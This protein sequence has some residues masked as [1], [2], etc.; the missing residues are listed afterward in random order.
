[1]T[2]PIDVAV[3]RQVY[4]EG[5]K[6]GLAKEY[7]EMIRKNNADVRRVLRGMEQDTLRDMTQ[8][9]FKALT[10]DLRASQ[11]DNIVDQ[12]HQLNTNLEGL[13]SAE[14]IFEVALL[15]Q[16]YDKVKEAH[17][18]WQAALKNPIQSSGELLEPFIKDL[19]AR[20]IARLENQL[21]LSRAR[22]MTIDQ[23]VRAFN[24][25]K[26]KGYSDGI[27]ARNWND[28]R[29]V[30]RTATQHVSSAARSA[31]WEAN[32]DIMDKYQWVSTLDG[33][34]SNVCK[35]LDGR[36]F[37]VGEGPTPPI[38]PNC[39]STTVP[40]FPPSRFDD[41]A[42]RS[43]EF[44]PVDVN[45]TYYEWLKDQPH[46]FQDDALGKTR[47]KLF[48]DGGLTEKEFSDLQ[49]GKDFLPLTLEEMKKKMPRAFE[50][51]NIN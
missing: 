22:G 3:R 1:M 48:R 5:L 24:G 29:T 33:V 37:V 44:G 25:T 19:S 38:H 6:E 27:M 16:A 8:R 28:A 36:V 34:T 47:A 17:N 50:K 7:G 39:R 35:S 2:D 26:A 45:T 12:V 41:G 32:S 13:A 23:T 4:L 21:R 31:V 49:I 51:A 15:A 42:T 10:D 46:D 40:Y 9:D 18:L 14:G 43:A 11:L 20:Q 30:I